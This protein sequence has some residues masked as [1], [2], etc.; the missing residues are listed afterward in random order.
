MKSVAENIRNARHKAGMSQ[1]ELAEKSGVS[2]S[3]LVCIEAGKFSPRVQTLV[4]IASALHIPLS[5]LVSN[6]GNTDT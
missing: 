4:A 3:H 6:V 2:R 1:A 5:K